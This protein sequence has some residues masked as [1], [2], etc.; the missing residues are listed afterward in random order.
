LNGER[1][2]QPGSGEVADAN[3]NLRNWLVAESKGKYKVFAH[4]EWEATDQADWKVVA[5]HLTEQE[6]AQELVR[7]A[8]PDQRTS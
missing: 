5:D 3:D 4:I 8:P 2:A 1:V 7:R 6:A